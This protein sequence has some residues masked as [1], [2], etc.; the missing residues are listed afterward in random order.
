[1]S[2]LSGDTV[3]ETIFWIPSIKTLISGDTLYNPDIH[4]WCADQETLAMTDS[5]L[6]TLQLIDSLAPTTIIP[7][8][9]TSTRPAKEAIQIVNYTRSYVEFFQTKL[10]PNANKVYTVQEIINL[11]NAEF[12]GT[13]NTDS[14]F[15]LKATAEE[16]GINGTGNILY[17]PVTEYT[18]VTILDGYLV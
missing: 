6:A 14:N 12:P 18:N 9:S 8:H 4:A 11:F 5:W 1:M 10:Q 15:I 16:F 3:H 17:T 2:P 7:G 13:N